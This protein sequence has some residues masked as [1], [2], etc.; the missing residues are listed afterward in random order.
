MRTLVIGDIHGAYLALIQV[1]ERAKVTPDD[2]LIFLGDYTDGWSDTPKVI[3]FLIE[4]Q[5]THNVITLRGNHDDLCM[6]FLGGNY[7]E[8]SW[9][10]HGGFSTEGAYRLV[11]PPV[12]LKHLLFLTK[13]PVHHYDKK[14]NRLFVHA[15]FTNL[16]GIEQEYFSKNFY[17]DRTLWE[18]A[19][20]TPT[21]MQKTDPFYPQRLKLYDEV[22]IGHTA[23]TRYNLTSPI[24]KHNIWNIDTGAGFSG[25][26]T[27]MDA[28]TKQYWQSDFV[29][30]LYPD[31]YGRIL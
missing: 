25:K 14:K 5:K 28:D 29:Y 24:C 13:L 20:A 16:K 8:E 6:E 22:F 19:L 18:L 4:L 3:D 15:G 30:N 21:T 11:P 7:M 17:W 1:M 2:L 23:S 26:L 10:T 12:Q 27:I 31:E 9:Y